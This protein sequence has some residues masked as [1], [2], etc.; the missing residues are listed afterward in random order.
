MMQRILPVTFALALF[1]AGCMQPAMEFEKPEPF[2][3]PSPEGFV[4]YNEGFDGIPGPAPS[5]PERTE[6]PN[7]AWIVEPPPYP[8]EVTVLRMHRTLPDPTFLQNITTALHIPAGVIRSNSTAESMTVTWKDDQGYRWTYDA[9]ENRIAFKRIEQSAI[10]TVTTLA[11]PNAYTAIADAFLKERGV[12]YEREWSEPLLAFNWNE[13]W[14]YMQ[15]GSRCMSTVSVKAMRDFARH[16]TFG[17]PT[18]PTLPFH[19]NVH[20]VEPEFPARQAVQYNL[21]QDGMEVYD[22]RGQP[23]AAA[24]LVVHAETNTVESGWFHLIQDVDRSNYPVKTER[25]FFEQLKTGGLRGTEPY[26]ANAAITLHAF[27]RGLYQ[28]TAEVNGIQRTYFIPGV[29]ASGKIQ[30]SDGTTEPF[31]TFVPL[32]REDAYKK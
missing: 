7:V 9:E 23:S 16:G 1:G 28:H 12:S 15:E 3:M 2:G 24:E 22:E 20:C 13:W 32:L 31:Q 4:M 11:D 8:T 19:T 27:S 25:D 18:P 21:N 14:E 6:G 26:P 17:D 5:V 10:Q 30:R 29:H